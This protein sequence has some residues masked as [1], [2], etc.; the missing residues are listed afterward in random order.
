M[1]SIPITTMANSSIA[2]FQLKRPNKLVVALLNFVKFSIVRDK[3]LY[4]QRTVRK[5]TFKLFFFAALRHSGKK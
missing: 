5:Y 2:V 3:K 1:A 4:K